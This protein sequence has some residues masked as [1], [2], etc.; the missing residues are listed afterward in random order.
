MSCEASPQHVHPGID[1]M[2]AYWL[3]RYH[4]F[5]DKDE[6]LQCLRWR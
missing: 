4:G 6:P 3:G 5:V 1:Y 2:M